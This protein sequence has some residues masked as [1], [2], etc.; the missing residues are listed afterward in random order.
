MSQNHVIPAVYLVLRREGKVLLLRRCNT[1]YADGNYSLIA[2]H[3]DPGETCLQ[4]VIR[5]AKEEAG[6]DLRS[7]DVEVRYIMHRD[8]GQKSEN[9]RMDVFYEAK[10]WSG[11]PVNMEPQKCDDLSWFAT[12]ALPAELLDYV[13]VALER[14][15]EGEFFSEFGWNSSSQTL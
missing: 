7:E 12:D 2:G 9:Q 15:E 8:S 3:V 13:K 6:L 11:E 4:A 10:Q 5:E 14:M 1:G